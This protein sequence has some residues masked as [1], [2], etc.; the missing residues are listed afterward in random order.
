MNKWLIG[1][2]CVAMGAVLTMQAPAQILTF[3]FSALAGNEETAGSNLNDDNLTASTIS[4]GAGLTASANA[5]RFNATQWAL[6]SIANAISGDKYMEFTITPQSG[7]QFTVSSIYVQWQRSATGNTEVSLRSSVDNYASDLD[8]NWQLEDVTTTQN[9]TWTFAQANSTTPVTYRLYSYAEAGTGSGG[10]GDGAGDDIVVYGTVTP[11]GPLE[12]SVS[13]DK[14]DGFEVEE[15]V[16]TMINAIAANGVEPYSYE[17][18]TTM[19]VGDYLADEETFGISGLAPVGGFSAT[20]TV[21][22]SDAPPKQVSN[23]INFT[24]VAPAP[25]YAITITPPVNGTV[26]T[27]PEDEAE[28]GQTVTINANPAGGYAVD[29]ITVV[30]AALNPVAVA[31]GAFTMPAS[32][33][34]VTVTFAESEEPDVLIDFETVTGFGGYAAGTSVVSGV[35]VRHENVMRGTLAGDAKNGAAAARFR[36]YATSN[37]FFATTEPFD[38]PISKITFWY[39]NYGTENTVTFVVEVSANGSEWTAVGPVFDPESTTLV[40]ATIDVIPSGMTYLQFRTVSGTASHRV[41]VDDIGIFLGASG[42]SVSFNK[43]DNFEIEEGA[44]DAIT[45]TASGGAAPY[46]YEWVSTLSGAHYEAI[47]N[48]FTILP[49][50]PVGG[51]SATVTATDDDEDEAVNTINFSVVAPTPKY[52]IFIVPAANGTITTIPVDEAEAGQ[53][54]TVITTP[55]PGYALENITVTQ[56]DTTPVPVTGNT[57]T[58]PAVAVYVTAS[59]IESQDPDALID[60][61]SGTLPGAYADNTAVLEDGKEWA[62]RRVLRS[63]HENDKKFGTYSARMY[64]VTTTNAYLQQSEPYAEPIT[65]LSFWVASYGTDNMANVVL[66]VQVSSDGVEWDTVATLAGAADITDTLVEHVIETIPEGAVYVRFFATAEAATNKRINID[67]IG[68]FHGEAAPY[69]TFTGSTIGTVGVQMALDF[70]LHGATAEGWAWWVMTADR[71][72]IVGAEGDTY[73]VRWTPHA[74]GDYILTVTA[75]GPGMEILA[76][77]EV[78]LTVNTS[79]GDPEVTITGDL[80][81]TVGEQMDLLVQLIDGTADRLWI[82]LRDPDNVASFAYVWDELTGEFSFTPTV[83]GTWNLSAWAVVGMDPIATKSQDLVV[84]EA[85]P[86]PPITTITMVPDGGGDFTFSVPEGWALVRVEGANTTLDDASE[87]AW[88]P[89]QPGVHYELD[90]MT[91]VVT[92]LSDTLMPGEIGR[93]IRLVLTPGQ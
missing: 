43:A 33:V 93:M 11:A 34:N 13:F 53:T 31:G 76:Q 83:A 42:F 65:K 36:H 4:R 73:Q 48:V 82:D 24:I 67:N 18:E 26:T 58:M 80:T 19:A 3:E 47:N 23:T 32:A 64:P 56:A 38:D 69:L 66:L 89:M 91:Q 52:D 39:A 27:T 1:L 44:G 55:D 90:E 5:Q 92:I 72:P 40:Q 61:E 6:E 7:Y 54:V 9:K 57:F 77:R 14:T 29:T 78:P 63:N 59:F 60:F 2:V 87:F 86:N 79:G 85:S 37:G 17:W 28:A 88:Y 35:S 15:G 74:A 51:Y 8:S 62:T 70:T 49:T 16:A 81:G 46:S 30:D 21:T 50:A 20:V 68:I 22:D 75:Y 12:F 84:S 10:P 25:K 45:A 41:N 71:D